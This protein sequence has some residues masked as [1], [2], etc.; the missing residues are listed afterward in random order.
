M[1]GPCKAD[2][3]ELA[4]LDGVLALDW[5]KQREALARQLSAMPPGELRGQIDAGIQQFSERFADYLAI[6]AG[7]IPASEAAN[8]LI[9][10]GESSLR[11]AGLFYRW[12]LAGEE[13]DEGVMRDLSGAVHR[14]AAKFSRVNPG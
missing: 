13:E 8:V 9:A 10:L 3:G 14:A 1:S 7:L 2:Q 12:M 4:R 6:G 11:L 5:A